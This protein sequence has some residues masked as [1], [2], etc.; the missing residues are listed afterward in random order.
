MA[1]ESYAQEFNR[2]LRP[3]SR[4]RLPHIAPHVNQRVSNPR[5]FNYISSYDVASNM[6]QALRAA[7]GAPPPP[8]GRERGRGRGRGRRRGLEWGEAAPSPILAG[9]HTLY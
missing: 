9:P 2:R 7:S 6:C 3:T 8:D 4:C 1:A 5:V